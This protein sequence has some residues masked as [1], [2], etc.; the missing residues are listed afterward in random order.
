MVSNIDALTSPVLSNVFMRQAKEAPC[1]Q[2][3]SLKQQLWV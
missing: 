2:H 3:V 1:D